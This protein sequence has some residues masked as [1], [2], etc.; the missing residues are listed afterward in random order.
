[1]QNLPDLAVLDPEDGGS[2]IIRNTDKHSP[3]GKSHA[4]QESNAR[5]QRCETREFRVGVT[6]VW[7]A[8]CRGTTCESVLENA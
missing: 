5:Q 3:S 7:Q 2:N 1:M 8:V 4:I 6:A